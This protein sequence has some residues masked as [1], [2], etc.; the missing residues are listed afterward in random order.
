[1]Y[2]N[3]NI[4]NKFVEDNNMVYSIDNMRLKTYITYPRFK[5]LEVFVNS[6]YKENISRFWI[7]DKPQCFHYNYAME[8]SSCSFYFAYMHNG[9]GVNFNRDDIEYNFTIDF[10]PN[11]VR[12]NP[13][14]SIILDRF[15]NWYLKSL[16]FAVDIPVSV[17]DLLIDILRRRK[18]QTVSY[19]GDNLTYYFGKGDG[20]VKIYNKKIE[21]N[22]KI[23]GNLTRVEVTKEFSDFP[24]CYLKRFKLEDNI[25]PCLYLNKYVF[26]FSDYTVRDKTLM[27]IL[28]AVQSGYPIKDLTRSYKVKLK[29]LLEA[30]SKIKFN[31]SSA[32]EAFKKTIFYYFVRR[33]SR[34]IIF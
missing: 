29:D 30:G 11:K 22:L 15:C 32:E 17:L 26:S 8:F 3:I 18:I 14:V 2:N 13:L 21:S 20:R 7:S 23:V 24:I 10:N 9:E 19:G 25:F 31:K 1:M 16:D 28:Y 12:D 5:E 27:A 4:Y 33:T 34:Q 6:V